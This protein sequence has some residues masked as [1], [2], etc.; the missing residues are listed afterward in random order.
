MGL[1]YFSVAPRKCHFP[2]EIVKYSEG[3]AHLV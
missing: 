1:R 3:V 2:A